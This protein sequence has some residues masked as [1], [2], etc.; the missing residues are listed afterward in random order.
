MD[1]FNERLSK[2]DLS[3]AQLS[4]IRDIRRRGKNKVA[5]QNCRK[6][7]LDQINSLS[8]EVKE[9]R[10]RKMRL[11]SEHNFMM[12]ESARVKEKFGRLYQHIFRVSVFFFYVRVGWFWISREIFLFSG[13]K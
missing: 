13:E 6:R 5:A 4:L 10:N 8:D 2:Y 1:E 3:E 11:L 7:K 12:Q 9:M